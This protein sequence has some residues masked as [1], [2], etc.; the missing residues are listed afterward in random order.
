MCCCICCCCCCCI[1]C[2]CRI[3]CCC[4]SSSSHTASGRANVGSAADAPARW[5]LLVRSQHSSTRSWRMRGVP[6]S[7]A[8]LPL[9]SA[10]GGACAL[11]R[12]EC[13]RG[14]GPSSGPSARCASCSNRASNCAQSTSEN[15]SLTRAKDA[16]A[17][18]PLL[19][20]VFA[21]LPAA[22]AR[23]TA[24]A[25]TATL[26]PV[27]GRPAA[28]SPSR[29]APLAAPGGDPAAAGGVAAAAAMPAP[30]AAPSRRLRFAGM[31]SGRYAA[32]ASALMA[33]AA[34]PLLS[35]SPLLACT[36]SSPAAAAA[37]A[38]GACACA[39]STPMGEAAKCGCG[40]RTGRGLQG[41]LRQS[42]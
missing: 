18:R 33:A 41:A 19:C 31:S 38:A 35:A 27:G 3:C 7:P 17:A 1:C 42:F 15:V 39:P 24:H 12:A 6:S 23:D 16:P 40:R 11:S 10:A 36:A 9:A 20:C 32:V 8:L 37:A 2:C 21:A 13:E 34:D 29:G 25:P 26:A 5:P 14:G 4:C 28:L 30:P 22:A